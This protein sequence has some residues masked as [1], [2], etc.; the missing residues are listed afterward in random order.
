M[1]HWISLATAA[2]GGL[3]PVSWWGDWAEYYPGPYGHRTADYADFFYVTALAKTLSFATRLGIA[4][5][6]TRYTQLLS[7]ASSLYLN[8]Y[9]NASSKTFVD[10]LYVSQL[11]GL[12]L[13]VAPA[14]DVPAVWANALQWIEAGGS[15]AK[16]PDHFGGGIIALKNFYSLVDSFNN[17]S[18][19]LSVQL[20]SDIPSFGYWVEQGATT[21][22]EGYDLTPTS[23]G[24]SYK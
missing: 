16:Y 17:R 1:E 24:L 13:G 7:D 12:A 6:I 21:L 19:G 11:F 5:D 15:S 22:W 23:G 10:G 20:Q 14:A 18:L 4:A 8:T 2:P 9:Y 3:F